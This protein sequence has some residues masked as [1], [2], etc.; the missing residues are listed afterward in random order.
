MTYTRKFIML[1]KEFSS[2]EGNIKGHGKLEVRGIRGAVTLNIENGEV[3]SVYKALLLSN[4][5][6]NSSF[7]LGKIFTDELGTGK[8]EYN[9]LQR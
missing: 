1:K 8:G 6:D 2:I 4:D 9:F 3:E 7:Y 5:K